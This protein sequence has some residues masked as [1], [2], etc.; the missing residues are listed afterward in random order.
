MNN[1][2]NQKEINYKMLILFIFFALLAGGIGAL[3]GR[4]Y[5]RF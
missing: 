3:L 1:N 2:L 5:E 4:K